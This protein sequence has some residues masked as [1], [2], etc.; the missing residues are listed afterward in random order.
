MRLAK[1]GKPSVADCQRHGHADDHGHD[2]GRLSILGGHDH[3]EDLRSASKRSLILALVL[4]SGFMIVEV[5][6]GVLA[7][8]LALLA[9]AGH[10]LTDAASIALALGAMYFAGKAYSAKRTYGYDR[11]EILAALVNVLAL[12]LIAIGIFWEAFQ[13]LSQPEQVNGAIVVAVGSAGLVVNLA[14][15]FILYG[16]ARHSL[17]VAGALAHV[18]ADLVASLGVVVSGGLIWAFG[19][20]LADSVISMLIGILVVISSWGLLAR[21][22]N[23]LLEGVPEHIDI[24]KLCARIEELNGVSQVHDIHVWTISPGYDALTAHVVVDPDH[25]GPSDAML[26]EIRTIVREKFGINHITVQI[27]H[28]AASCTECHDFDH[29]RMNPRS[30]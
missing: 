29:L 25:A 22:V 4:I 24:Y 19:W 9:D 16:A 17:N 20:T 26:A 1:S 27:E 28:S 13:R 5:A 12:W 8:S 3:H 7:G 30:T 2:H 21:I 11:L 23:V 14:A 10:M 6:G 18:L 15:A